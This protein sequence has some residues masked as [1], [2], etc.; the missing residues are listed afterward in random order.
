MKPKP[1]GSKGYARFSRRRKKNAKKVW[2]NVCE[3]CTGTG[4][5][6]F[7]NLPCSKGCDDGIR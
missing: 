2:E 3:H 6:P 1:K 7:T 5:E 4:T